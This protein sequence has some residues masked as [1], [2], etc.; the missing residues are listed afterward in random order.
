[1]SNH[2][3]NVKTRLQFGALALASLCLQSTA[4]AQSAIPTA[5]LPSRLFVGFGSNAVIEM[6]INSATLARVQWHHEGT[7]LP[8]ETNATL[9]IT[10]FQATNAGAYYATIRNSAAAIASERV[11][12]L[13]YKNPPANTGGTVLFSTFGGGVNAPV[14]NMITGS[15]VSGAAGFIAQLYGGPAGSHESELQPLGTPQP[16]RDGF[17]AGYV[18]DGTVFVNSVAPGA[19]ATIQMRV[20]NLQGG[21][22]FEEAWHACYPYF[23]VS[24][25]IQVQ[26]GIDGDTNHPPARLLGLS[27]MF[28]PP[29]GGC[30]IHPSPTNQVVVLG[31]SSTF[32]TRITL[33]GFQYRVCGPDQSVDCPPIQW[34]RN[35]QIIPGATNFTLVI[36]NVSVA[37]AG[38]YTFE[39]LGIRSPTYDL[40]VLLVPRFA[41]VERVGN[42]A[43][44]LR[45]DAPKGETVNLLSSSNLVDWASAGVQSNASGTVEFIQPRTTN[46]TMFYRATSE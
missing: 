26:T 44:R 31:Q 20:W 15:R 35:G 17:L 42:S 2:Q 45:V 28:L 3:E 14:T 25:L 37:D 12:V 6:V 32:A 36:T 41:A 1:L 9:T 27:S 23:G 22:T 34:K 13:A 4:L 16:F 7:L 11:F 5:T 43:M 8:G 29:L 46:T 24:G 39:F 40:T 21:E 19:V 18:L 33:D 38:K 30:S 10:N